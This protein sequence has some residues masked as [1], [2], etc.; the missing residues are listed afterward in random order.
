MSLSDTYTL[1]N[2]EPGTCFPWTPDFGGCCEEFVEHPPELQVRALS[3]AW[4]TIRALTGGRAGNCP[5]TIRPCLRNDV[6]TEC[7]GDSWLSP[8]VDQWGDW[9]NAACRRSGD[10]SCCDMCEIVM[11]GPVAAI[12]EVSLDGIVLETPMFRIDNGNIL[13]RQ[14]GLCWPACQNLSAPLGE[15]GTLGVTYVP[16]VLPTEAGMWAAATLACEYAKACTGGKCRLPSNIQSIARQGVTMQ[17]SEGDMLTNGTGIREV[18]AYILSVNPNRLRTPPKV[19]SPDMV[20]PK[21]RFQTFQ[22]AWK[23]PR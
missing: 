12:T 13:V 11:P 15:I 23:R 16:G 14:D 6:C 10:C 19:Y 5:V 2:Q 4:S 7:F 18:D 22:A 20:S 1:G 9:K 17:L 3:L 8:Y 21:H